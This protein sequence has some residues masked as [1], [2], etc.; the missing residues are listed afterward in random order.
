[1]L[2]SNSFCRK[3]HLGTVSVHKLITIYTGFKLSYESCSL[4]Y[5][6][7]LYNH[8][9]SSAFL[10]KLFVTMALYQSPSATCTGHL[11]FIMATLLCIICV[12][13]INCNVMYVRI[14]CVILSSN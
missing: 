6:L 2:V 14:N 3:Y 11:Q 12:M 7:L 4:N 9:F 13:F 10:V 5:T 1:M 8:V